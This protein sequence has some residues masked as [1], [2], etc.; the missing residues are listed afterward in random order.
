MNHSTRS[1]FF[2]TLVL[3][4]M[5]CDGDPRHATPEGRLAG[6]VRD[7]MTQ[8]PL[9]DAELTLLLGGKKIKTTRSDKDGRYNIDGVP[10]GSELWLDIK[11]EGYPVHRFT[12]GI[13][14]HA[15]EEAQSNTIVLAH[16][17]IYPTLP[18]SL[19]VTVENG[20]GPQ[21]GVPVYLR[22]KQGGKFELPEILQA[23]TDAAGI[24][25]ISGIA[26]TQAYDVWVYE[27]TDSNTLIQGKGEF[28]HVFTAEESTLALK[29]ESLTQK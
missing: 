3:A 6:D 16:H 15:G 2:A 21:M 12:T 26:A 27:L 13:D 5:A 7:A 20:D 10:A 11:K 19:K 8:A 22:G 25:M 14:D 1:V 23:E 28:T 9:A 24:A 4:L 18:I 17:D 29:V